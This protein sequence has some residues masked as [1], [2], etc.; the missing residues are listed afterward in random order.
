AACLLM[1]RD[2]FEAINGYDETLAVGFGDVDLCL[3][4]RAAGYR[5]IFCPQATLIHH[6]SYSRGKTFQ[7]DPHP[8][9]SAKFFKRW[10]SIIVAGDPYSNP[11]I[12]ISSQEWEPKER[13][14]LPIK[15][16]SRCY[17]LKT[18][19][20]IGPDAPFQAPD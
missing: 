19:Q 5:V 9:D 1:R 2:A 20:F 3:R 6:E 18:H 10:K 11:N 13:L 7:G 15:T 8:E 14:E 12:A 17:D 16:R 4:T